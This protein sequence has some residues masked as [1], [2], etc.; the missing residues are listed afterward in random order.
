MHS[1]ETLLP[2]VEAYDRIAS[3]YPRLA[4]RRRLYLAAIEELIL[5]R[6]PAGSASLLDIGAG[7][8]ERACRIAECSGIKQVVLLE[9]SA[10][11]RAGV[12]PSVEVWPVRVEELGSVNR[13]FHVI[14]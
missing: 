1:R 7:D 13:D 6:I 3:I 11:M 5:S 4:E 8:G 10:G 2:P 12:N 14:T 9:P